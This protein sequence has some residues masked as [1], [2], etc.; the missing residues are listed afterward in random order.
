MFELLAMSD[1]TNCVLKSAHQVLTGHCGQG[2]H[3]RRVCLARWRIIFISS[4]LI[5]DSQS[6]KPEILTA[7]SL[8]Q[9]LCIF[10]VW[11]FGFSRKVNTRLKQ[12]S[13]DNG[14]VG[15]D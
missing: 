4:G 5:Q 1:L 10:H 12:R 6:T 8:I 7:I 3:S 15:L 11:L 13:E 9:S 2:C 14:A